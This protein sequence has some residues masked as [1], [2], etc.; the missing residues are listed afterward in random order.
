MLPHSMIAVS[1]IARGLLLSFDGIQLAWDSVM[2]TPPSL[3]EAPDST[4]GSAEHTPKCMP[5]PGSAIVVEL[6]SVYE[7]EAPAV[8]TVKR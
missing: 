7:T 8:S 5:R 1:S 4:K 6:K 3:H 2:N